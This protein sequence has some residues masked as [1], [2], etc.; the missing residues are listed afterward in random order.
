[1]MDK[2]GVQDLLLILTRALLHMGE[3]DVLC[4]RCYEVY[5]PGQQCYCDPSYDE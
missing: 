5:G 3:D 4:P 1:M 2:A